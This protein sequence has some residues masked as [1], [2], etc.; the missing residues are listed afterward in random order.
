VTLPADVKTTNTLAN[1]FRNTFVGPIEIVDKRIEAEVDPRN[2]EVRFGQLTANTMRAQSLVASR[3]MNL[4]RVQVAI[5]KQSAPA[6]N[7]VIE[8]RSD[9]SG[10][11]SATVLG[12]VSRPASDFDTGS[13]YFF[14]FTFSPVLALTAGT[15]YWIVIRRSGAVDLTNHYGLDESGG[16]YYT[17]GGSAV[18]DGAAWTASSTDLTFRAMADEAATY[19]YGVTGNDNFGSTSA[20]LHRSSDGGHTWAPYNN[21]QRPAAVAFTARPS[22]SGRFELGYI[23][24]DLSAYSR[25][26]D[27]VE[28]GIRATVYSGGGSGTNKDG[29]RVIQAASRTGEHVAVF[30]KATESVMGTAY[31]R[32]GLV[33]RTTGAYSSVIDIISGTTSGPGT[34]VH[35]DLQTVQ[36]GSGDQMHLFWIQSDNAQVKTRIFKSDHTFTTIINPASAVCNTANK[37]P[38]GLPC[39]Y[40]DGADTWIAVPYVDGSAIKILRAKSSIADIVGNWTTETAVAE[41]PNQSLSNP[42]CLM[43]DVKKLW[44]WFVTSADAERDIAF[45]DDGGAALWTDRTLWKQG[46]Q[47][48]CGG[49]SAAAITDAVGVLYYDEEPTPARVRFDKLIIFQAQL[50]QA[51]STTT[52]EYDL[53]VLP[54]NGNDVQVLLDVGGGGDITGTVDVV[55]SHRWGDSGDYAEVSRASVESNAQLKDLIQLSG[56]GKWLKVA[57]TVGGAAANVGAVGV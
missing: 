30:Q 12:S 46:D 38:L 31:R 28:G 55:I 24:T 40:L 10:V 42:C 2:T 13:A 5:R 16:D 35:Y 33:Y 34:Q 50:G 11:P 7:V 47:V 48:K 51:V 21:S 15:R 45:C 26:I 52:K 25:T 57:T 22:S 6:D 56:V 8:L 41:A 39:T 1:G 4:L 43:S 44:L 49:I 37:Y 20:Q 53:G 17:A 19:L 14:A 3:D 23:S 36:V 18:Y 9:A 32:V 54:D 29:L 27:T